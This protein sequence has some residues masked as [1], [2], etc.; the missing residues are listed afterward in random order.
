MTPYAT[1]S[2]RPV[3]D[4]LWLTRPV[5]E[6]L[7]QHHLIQASKTEYLLRLLRINKLLLLWSKRFPATQ[8]LCFLCAGE[9]VLEESLCPLLEC[10]AT[11]SQLVNILK[12]LLR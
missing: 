3:F 6:A 9:A 4:R 2:G 7:C 10:D 12:E 5:H 11:F 1:D 8:T